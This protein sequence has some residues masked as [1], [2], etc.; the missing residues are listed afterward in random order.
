M[1]KE[2]FDAF[3][4]AHNDFLKIKTKLAVQTKTYTANFYN[5]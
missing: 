1:L 4:L 2:D 5:S 3:A